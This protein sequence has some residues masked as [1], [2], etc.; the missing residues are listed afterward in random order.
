M[1][2]TGHGRCRK[3]GV[4]YRCA[5]SAPLTYLIR[6]VNLAGARREEGWRLGREASRDRLRKLGIAFAETDV[7]GADLETTI[8]DLMTGQHKN[9]LRVVTFNTAEPWSRD[10]SEDI[11]R[12]IV[13]RLGLAGQE[14][15]S[16]IEAFVERHLGSDRQL[17][18]RLA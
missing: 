15:P 10:A 1:T 14:L 4:G 8:N 17:T 11:A 5:K 2:R 3:G 6:A 7:G 13:R 16:S 12:E 9:P 18:L